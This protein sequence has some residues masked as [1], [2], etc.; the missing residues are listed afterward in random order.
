MLD[1]GSGCGRIARLLMTQS[2]RPETYL[3]FNPHRGMV[4]W[5]RTHLSVANSAFRFV[6]LDIR[7]P[8]NPDGVA[9]ILPFTVEEPA[10]LVIALP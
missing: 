7:C 6:H 5:C 10:T 1:I 9:D 8:F 3:G 2:P 4:Q